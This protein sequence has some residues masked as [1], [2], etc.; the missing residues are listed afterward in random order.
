M[1]EALLRRLAGDRFE[2]ESA[3]LEPGN[4]N[5]LAVEALKDLGI[6]ISGKK[7]QNVFDLYKQGRVFHYVIAVCDE[8]SERCPIFQVW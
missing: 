3:G 4:I 2:P 1:A 8:A 5:P 7:T 6:D